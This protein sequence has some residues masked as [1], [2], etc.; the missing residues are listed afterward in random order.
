MTM[1]TTTTISPLAKADN[2]VNVSALLGARHDADTAQNPATGPGLCRSA[3]G[4]TRL[5]I[6]F[7]G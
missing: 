1:T 2:G 7:N 5:V 3:S 4:I 6:R